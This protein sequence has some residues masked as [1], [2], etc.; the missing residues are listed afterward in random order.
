ME[1]ESQNS[2]TAQMGMGRRGGPS[3]CVA[4]VNDTSNSVRVG[5]VIIGIEIVIQLGVGQEGRI[6]E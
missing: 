3:H 5:V 1:H 6:K 4:I 2:R